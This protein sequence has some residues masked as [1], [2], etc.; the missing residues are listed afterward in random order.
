MRF[1]RLAP[2]LFVIAISLTLVPSGWAAIVTFNLVPASSNLALS[3]DFVSSPLLPQNGAS[4]ATSYAG[5]IVADL[6]ASTITFTGASNIDANQL[7]SN[8][9]P[10]NNG[11]PGSR[12]A[13]YGMQSATQ[14]GTALGAIRSLVFNT[15]SSS[16]MNIVGNSFSAPALSTNSGNLDYAVGSSAAFGRADL[17]GISSGNSGA[18]ATLV[19]VGSTQTLTIPVNITIPAS[20]VTSGD[21]NLTYAGTLVA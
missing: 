12:A 13:D 20:T 21:T 3:G 6:T 1:V 11:L 10:D 9:Q 4:T 8:Q 17:S 16:V 5:T 18:A 7:A 2:A 19:T 15:P 14:F